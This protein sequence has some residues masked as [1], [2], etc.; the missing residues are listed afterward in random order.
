MSSQSILNAAALGFEYG[1]VTALAHIELDLAPGEVLGLIG[2]NGSG[3]STLLKCLGS[4]QPITSGRLDIC[5]RP[6]ADYE[7]SALARTLAY[8]PQHVGASMSLRVI[9]MVA[10]G[11]LPYRGL[12]SEEKNRGIVLDAVEHM[13]LEPLALRYF[14]ELSG[15]ER[16][17]VLI[18]RALAQQGR[19][20]LLDEP[21]SDLDLKHQLGTMQAVRSIADD[22]GLGA[23]I[24]IHD[25]SLAARF[26]D[27]LVML[28]GGRIYAQGQ[29]PSVL[30]P[31]GIEAVYGVSA[32]VGMDDGEPYVI[33]SGRIERHASL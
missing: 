29:W 3:N 30:T 13:H 33:A 31:A 14:S 6:I 18:A 23:V 11:R 16:Q 21:T 1:E 7:R 10:L 20:L 4:L 32:K 24:A 15:G 26:C 2:P 28:R 19:L 5:G 22:K 25:L 12:C 17:R 8:V 27:R 9:D